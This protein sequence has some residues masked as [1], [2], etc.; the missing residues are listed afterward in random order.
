MCSTKNKTS[1]RSNTRRKRGYKRKNGPNTILRL[2]KI[3]AKEINASGEKWVKYYYKNRSMAGLPEAKLQMTFEELA[4]KTIRSFLE[5]GFSIKEII[6][7]FR[8]NL[9]KKLNLIHK[10]AYLKNIGR[11]STLE[12]LGCEESNQTF[13]VD[14]NNSIAI[15]IKLKDLKDNDGNG[16]CSYRSTLEIEKSRP[17]F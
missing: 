16:K 5:R 17:R 11:P 7:G 8:K 6:T 14:W 9:N 2:I 1:S 15:L 4:N 13:L 10:L 3:R 12:G